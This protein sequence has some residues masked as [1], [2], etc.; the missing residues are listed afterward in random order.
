[1]PK[2][3]TKIAGGKIRIIAGQLRNSRLIVPDSAGLRPTADRVRETLFNWLA[4]VIDGAHCLDLFAGTGALGIEALSRGAEKVTFIEQD[5]HLA[6]MLEANLAR[7]K[8]TDAQVYRLD[9]LAFLATSPV[10][11]DV[12]FLD[13]PFKT[14]LGEQIAQKLEEGVWLKPQ[15]WI[16][17]ESPSD[18]A[19]AVPNAWIKYREGH[20]GKVRFC[21]YRRDLRIR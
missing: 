5:T 18:M 11:F 2:N 10:A 16:Y 7:L 19:P 9:A 4:P 14:E 1:M 20:A 12:V 13:P 8:I 21:L 17:L 3:P 15:A 6:K